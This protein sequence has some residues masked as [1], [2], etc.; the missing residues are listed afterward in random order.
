MKFKLIILMFFVLISSCKKE[1]TSLEKKIEGTW[2]LHSFT[3]GLTGKV[4]YVQPGNG[5]IYK[6]SSNQ[7]QRFEN[8]Q[9]I[10]TGTFSIKKDTIHLVN[11]I[12]NKII[13][14]NNN[15]GLFFDLDETYLSFFIDA[16]DGGGETYKRITQPVLE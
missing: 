8:R 4:T 6:F 2:E 7:F 3:M 9:L 11:R 16:N 12:G 1:N 15:D 10:K 14:N 5:E 13:F